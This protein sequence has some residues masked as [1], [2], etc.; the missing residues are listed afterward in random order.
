MIDRKKHARYMRLWRRQKQFEA[1]CKEAGIYYSPPSSLQLFNKPGI[2][3]Q[4]MPF[5]FGEKRL[6]LERKA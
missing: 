4:F 1:F 2:N 6:Q 3:L 5:S